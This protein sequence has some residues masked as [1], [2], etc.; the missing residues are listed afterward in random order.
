MKSKRVRDYSNASRFGERKIK[1]T[2]KNRKFIVSGGLKC[3]IEGFAKPY[4]IIVTLC[5]LAKQSPFKESDREIASLRSQK[6]S[7]FAKP[8]HGEKQ[9][10]IL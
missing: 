10:Q 4:L 8:S 3:I 7:G 5:E 6:A 2:Y 1:K 9:P